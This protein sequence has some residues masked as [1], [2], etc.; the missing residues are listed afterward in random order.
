MEAVRV[1]A[2]K[3]VWLSGGGERLRR[4]L[5]A[6]FVDGVAP[7]LGPDCLGTVFR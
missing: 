7:A 2:R 3:A 4:L 1:N 6:R 5:D